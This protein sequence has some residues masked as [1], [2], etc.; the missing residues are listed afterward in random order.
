[1]DLTHPFLT[2]QIIAYI[3]NK[4]RL[5]GLI[6]KGIGAVYG[7]APPRGLR[8]LDAFAGSGVVSR[9]AKVM[10]FELHINDWEAYAE[11]LS[12]GYIGV[13]RRDIP[14]LF[15]SEREFRELLTKLNQ[16]PPPDPG[17]Q[18]MARFY[19][20][21]HRDPEQADFRTERLFYT[22][23]N[24][25]SIDKIRNGI[26]ALYPQEKG[27]SAHR[28]R[29]DLLTALLLYQAATHTNT[30]G[31]F[32]ACHKGFGGHGRDALKRITAPIRLIPPPLIDRTAPIRIYRDDINHLIKSGAL[33]SLDIA[34][35][36][37]PYNQHQ[38][39]SNYH[40]LNSVARWDKPEMPLTLDEKG[41]LQEKAGIRH[42]WVD[43]RSAYCYRSSAAEAFAGLIDGLDAETI[44]ISYSS[45]GL[46]PLEQM[47]EICAEKGRFRLITNEYTRYR[48]GK[49]SNN[50]T[51]TNIEF[52][53]VLESGKPPVPGDHDTLKRLLALRKTRLLF[54][55][56]CR[57]DGLKGIARGTGTPSSPL[58]L[59]TGRKTITI[60][61]IHSFLLLPP[62]E[63]EKLPPEELA[64]LNNLLE[65][66]LC[67]SQ[68]EI[69]QELL[70][71]L[72][73]PPPGDTAPPSFFIRRIAPALKKLAH[74]KNRDRFEYWSRRI[75]EWRE[76]A[77]EAAEW[78]DRPLQEVLD[79]A[80][81]RFQS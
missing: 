10:G 23:E 54:Q 6:H 17:E 3:G 14:A 13:D 8:F 35:L 48:G 64:A 72:E 49:Q 18:Y 46:V 19:A 71:R 57:Y 51:N 9:L 38:Y 53:I 29:R 31:V 74:K 30:S 47:E 73:N 79:I 26:E 78:L 60:P 50:R 21:A 36:D 39:G 52:L 34:Y 27:D 40:I 70:K 58:L 2:E 66:T 15:G 43:T 16:A 62:P 4:R 28:R 45:D 1:M 20:P 76:G 65:E 12:R 42:D 56:P 33:P 5:L 61:H 44:L 24:A 81:K 75:A 25:L 63:L 7:S 67:R 37:P 55:H 69:L 80:Q 41:E 22:R 11:V 77:P 59:N 32:K 68:E